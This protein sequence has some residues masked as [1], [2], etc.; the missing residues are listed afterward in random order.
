MSVF[1]PVVATLQALALA[2]ALVAICPCDPPTKGSADP[3]ACCH[4]TEAALGA[5][6][7]GCC[8]DCGATDT[9][10]SLEPSAGSSKDL[11]FALAVLAVTPRPSLPRVAS[12][13]PARSVIQNPHARSAPTPLRI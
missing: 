8:S 7:P 13:F 5:V 10:V 6:D 4:E 2:L 11:G 9:V 3:H 1:R 12:R